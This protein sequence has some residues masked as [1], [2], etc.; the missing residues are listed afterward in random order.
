MYPTAISVVGVCSSNE[1]PNIVQLVAKAESGAVVNEDGQLQSGLV[2]L[3]RNP[4][5]DGPAIAS[6]VHHHIL[7]R[8]HRDLVAVLRFQ[9]DDHLNRNASVRSG[10]LRR[11]RHGDGEHQHDEGNYSCQRSNAG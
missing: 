6:L 10:L 7:L 11:N 9:G 1:G 2:S 3:C 4:A 8:D 5:S